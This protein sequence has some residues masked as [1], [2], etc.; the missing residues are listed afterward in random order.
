MFERTVILI[1]RTNI[2][3]GVSVLLYGDGIHDDSGGIQE[4]LDTGKAEIALPMPKDCYCISRPLRVHSNQHL[5]LG[6]YCVIKLMS[7]ANCCMLENADKET[8]NTNIEI[9]GGI[10]DMN[11]LGQAKNPFSFPNA[12][13]PEYNGIAVFFENVANFR[14]ANL[15][16]KDPVTFAITL[17][18][19][20]YFTVEDI[21]FDFNYGN[22]WAINMDGVHLDGQCHYGVIRNLKGTCYDDMVALNADEGKGGPI[23]NI[24]IDGLFSVNCHSAVRLLSRQYP[25]ENIHIHNVYGTYYQYCIGLTS[26]YK[27]EFTGYYDGIV[28]ENIH[29]SKAERLSVYK[30][31]GFY[32]YPFIWVEKDLLVRNLH[33]RDIYRKEENVAVETVGIEENAH[34]ENLSISHAVQENMLKDAP[35]AL[36]ANRGKVDILRMEAL[37][38]NGGDV[39]ANS[40]TIGKII[41][42]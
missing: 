8:G 3:I 11:N 6:R 25:V 5:A 1:K 33:I 24:D 17:N 37:R 27:N 28:L 10:W 21:T 32:V 35:F 42:S 4:L 2:E 34:I 20:S 41:E 9:T 39:L 7:N 14:M 16:M 31:D 29:A 12:D 18:I 19:V 26:F 40:G 15:T 13:F 23:T 38:T 30:K 22:P 36:I